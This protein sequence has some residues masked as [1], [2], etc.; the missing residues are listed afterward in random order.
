MTCSSTRRPA[1]GTRLKRL[2]AVVLMA[3]TLGACMSSPGT[4]KN[5][6]LPV[7]SRQETLDWARQL[8]GHLAQK[9]D[10]RINGE[11][12]E[13]GFSPCVGRNGESAPDDRY[14]LLY[15]VHSDVPG[16]RHNDVVRTVRDLLK[17]EGMVIS[18][19]HETSTTPPNSTVTARHPESRYVATVFSTGDTRMALSVTTPCLLP[20]SASPTATP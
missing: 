18:S 3:V 1:A 13:A 2:L 12:E 6:P 7:K 17:N 19:Y 9:A 16:A 15:F 5:D 8:M 10:I 4:G 20:P 11:P 14:T